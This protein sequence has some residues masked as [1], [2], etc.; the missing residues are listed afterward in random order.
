MPTVVPIAQVH[1]SHSST[2]SPSLT[3]PPPPSSS[4]SV[5]GVKPKPAKINVEE[6]LD[7]LWNNEDQKWITLFDNMLRLPLS[8]STT[9]CSCQ[10]DRQGSSS[11]D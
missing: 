9:R 10:T 3:P 2:S 8:S 1:M 11:S 5:D 7:S 6:V 4:T